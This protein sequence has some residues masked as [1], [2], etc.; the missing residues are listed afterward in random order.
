MLHHIVVCFHLAN[1]YLKSS[2]LRYW[3]C[4][5]FHSILYMYI[6]STLCILASSD[7]QRRGN[8]WSRC[9]SRGVLQCKSTTCN[10]QPRVWHQTRNLDATS[11]WSIPFSTQQSAN[12]DT[13]RCVYARCA[14][15]QFP[16]QVYSNVRQWKVL[17]NAVR[18]EMVTLLF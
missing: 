16:I 13:S 3:S 9:A 2:F 8:S 10:C 11:L 15:V 17:A 4:N 14:I 1:E 6:L 12:Q 5:L 7:K 18:G